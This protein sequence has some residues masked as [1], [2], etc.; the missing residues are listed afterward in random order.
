MSCLI[1]CASSVIHNYID[2]QPPFANFVHKIANVACKTCK[3]SKIDK[4]K[5]NMQEF[6][7]G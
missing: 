3:N 5:G 2:A 7:N 6:K 4:T 1:G